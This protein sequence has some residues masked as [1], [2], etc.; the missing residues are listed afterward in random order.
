MSRHI[1]KNFVC[2]PSFK[3]I[4]SSSPSRKNITGTTIKTVSK[5]HPP[6]DISDTICRKEMD[7]DYRRAVLCV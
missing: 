7:I 2:V 6:I 3:L 5:K 1:Q 4:N